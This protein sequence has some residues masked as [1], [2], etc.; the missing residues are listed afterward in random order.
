MHV[1]PWIRMLSRVH[2]FPW[3]HMFCAI[4]WQRLTSTYLATMCLWHQVYPWKCMTNSLTPW[5]IHWFGIN[6]CMYLH[7][8]GDTCCHRHAALCYNFQCNLEVTAIGHP[9][10]T[11]LLLPSLLLPSRNDERRND[12]RV[13]RNLVSTYRTNACD[14]NG[15]G[16]WLELHHHIVHLH[17]LV[18]VERGRVWLP[19]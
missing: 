3:M 15:M 12:I 16:G 7:Y 9:L 17:D 10:C 19:A 11:W 6:G 14:S 4:T 2:V 8:H 13:H 1:L 18:G 5:Y